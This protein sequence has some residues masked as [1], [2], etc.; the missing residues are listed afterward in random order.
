MNL[1]FEEKVRKQNSFTNI[2][3]KQK[4]MELIL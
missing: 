2:W 1:A 4:N 3:M